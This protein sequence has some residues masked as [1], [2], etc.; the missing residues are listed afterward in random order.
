[1]YGVFK[2]K[3]QYINIKYYSLEKRIN[4]MM[5]LLSSA[6]KLWKRLWQIERNVNSQKSFDHFEIV[7]NAG[8]DRCRR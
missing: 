8:I 4:G 5:G 7:T 2:L 6:G 3:I 1:M